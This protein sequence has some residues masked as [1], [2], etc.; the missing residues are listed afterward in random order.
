METELQDEKIVEDMVGLS[1]RAEVGTAGRR[2]GSSF[3]RGHTRSVM[4]CG[5]E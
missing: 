3:G 2:S 1:Q 5:P 4:A